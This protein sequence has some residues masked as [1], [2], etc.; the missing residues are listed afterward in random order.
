MREFYQFSGWKIDSKLALII[1][2]MFL[3]V[4]EEVHRDI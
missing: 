3:I 1:A 4:L 2:F